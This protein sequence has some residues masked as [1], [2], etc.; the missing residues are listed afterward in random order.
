MKYLFIL[1]IILLI[2]VKSYGYFWGSKNANIRVYEYSDYQCP[3]CAKFENRTIP[4]IYQNYIKKGAVSFI[5]VDF[6]LSF[7]KYAK[8]AAR[9]ADCSNNYIKVRTILYEYQNDWT[10]NGNINGILRLNGINPVDSCK[11]VNKYIS[12][13]IKSGNRL[14]IDATPTFFVFF[15]NK[16]IK[17]ITGYRNFSFWNVLLSGIED[18]YGR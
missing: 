2:P 13:E 8:K 1:F 6:P 10:Y 7:H 12:E 3:F 5:F 9:V 18:H 4:L 16:F 14:G 15:R 11:G 17:K